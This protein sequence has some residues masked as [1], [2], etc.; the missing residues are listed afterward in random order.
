[1][2]SDYLDTKTSL[3]LKRSEDLKIM[4]MFPIDVTLLQLFFSFNLYFSLQADVNTAGTFC[5]SFI[6]V[7]LPVSDH[8]TWSS[9]KVWQMLNQVL[10]GDFSACY[11]PSWIWWKCEV[12]VI[13]G[14]K[15]GSQKGVF[16]GCV[17]TNGFHESSEEYSL[18]TLI[19]ADSISWDGLRFSFFWSLIKFFLEFLI[20]WNIYIYVCTFFFSPSRFLVREDKPEDCN[21]T[22]ATT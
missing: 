8:H 16:C 22:M 4:Q 10:M 17:I 1:M 20:K 13:P 18:I 7:M 19:H 14:E 9:W 12:E 5:S 6:F 21:V 2:V 11:S 15:R 3:I